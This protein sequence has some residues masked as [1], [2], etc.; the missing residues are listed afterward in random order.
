M[1]KRVIAGYT[2]TV[3]RG[4]I[5]EFVL[6]LG[7]PNP[8]YTD[9]EAARARGYRDLIAPPTF[10]IVI[11]L[12]S[13]YDF[14]AQTRELGMD[15][16]LVLHG[17]QEYLYFGPIHPGDT[18]TACQRLAADETK[19]GRTG[20][21]RLVRV[22][23]VYTNQRG[24]RV[25]VGRS[26]RI[27]REQGDGSAAAGGDSKG[28]EPAKGGR[29][30]D[31]RPRPGPVPARIGGANPCFRDL[32][33]GEELPSL[34]K[35]PVDRVQLVR[36]AGASGDFNPLHTVT[37]FAVRAGFG[38]VIAHGMLVMGFAAQAVAGWVP[39]GGSL[40]RLGVRFV[41]PTRPGDAITVS[42]RVT[43][44]RDDEALVTGEVTAADQRGEVKLTG[45]FE[46]LWPER[47]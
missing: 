3:E 8:L 30:E 36:Y 14:W 7:D 34:V 24:E 35:E 25:L 18:I 10:G 27:Q 19:R 47:E 13:G 38:G 23:T 43:G 1:G 45:G 2:H 29:P 20:A 21:M 11:D 12:W 17:E 37:A 41:A 9:P 44:K 15:P 16:F 46:A 31:S 32:R 26:T 39:Q 22:E 6:A 42:G 40:K 28:V 5:R 4:K 33:V